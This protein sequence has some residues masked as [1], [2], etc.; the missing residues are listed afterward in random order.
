MW[1]SLAGLE[2]REDAL[3][4]IAYQDK[5]IPD[6][7]CL[8]SSSYHLYKCWFIKQMSLLLL[9]GTFVPYNLPL[10]QMA[11]GNWTHC[12]IPEADKDGNDV[13]EQTPAYLHIDAICED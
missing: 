9:E 11:K 13:G 4:L 2:S 5:P 6:F 10:F 7:S 8:V 3:I 12:W 1:S